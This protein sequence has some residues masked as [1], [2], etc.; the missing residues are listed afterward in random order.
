MDARDY[1]RSDGCNGIHSGDMENMI[2]KCY[3]RM[4]S[5]GYY[6]DSDGN[7]YRYDGKYLG[8]G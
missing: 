6:Y 4:S 1:S 2:K 7:V 3:V 5:D 8:K